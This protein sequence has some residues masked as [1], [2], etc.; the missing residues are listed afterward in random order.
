[1]VAHDESM[2]GRMDVGVVGCGVHKLR[3]LTSK[4]TTG[5]VKFAFV[6]KE[7]DCFQ[8]ELSRLVAAGMSND[9]FLN[10]LV[11]VISGCTA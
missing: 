8:R 3:I 10:S 7:D 6:V 1:M 2:C 11:P 5:T 9:K 4:V